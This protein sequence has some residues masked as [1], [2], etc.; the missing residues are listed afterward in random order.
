MAVTVTIRPA[1]TRRPSRVD[2]TDL[3]WDDRPG[4]GYEIIEDAIGAPHMSHV[5]YE[6]GTFSVGRP[7]AKRL[8]LELA[9]RFNRVHVVQFGGSSVCTEACWNND[10]GDAFACDCS[11]AGANHGQGDTNLVAPPPP[12]PKDR[13]QRPLP[14]KYDVFVSSD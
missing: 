11:C 9:Q 12:A 14:R 13:R 1:T 3:P 8:I 4:S 6:N 10:D 5:Q 2:V 7:Y